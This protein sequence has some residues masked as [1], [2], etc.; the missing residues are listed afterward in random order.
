MVYDWRQHQQQYPKPS[1][2]SAP[3]NEA[4]VEIRA[5]A[6]G[7]EAALFAAELFDMYKRYAQLK[8]WNFSVI[9]TSNTDIGGLKSVVFE[10]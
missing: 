8:N 3:D 4:I 9:D 2:P 5:G 7:Q 10:V 6:G 1:A